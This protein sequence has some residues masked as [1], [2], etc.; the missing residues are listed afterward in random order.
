[1]LTGAT[2][3]LFAGPWVTKLG[4]TWIQQLPQLLYAVVSSDPGPR[5]ME[6]QDFEVNNAE[7]LML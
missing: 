6:V 1:M 3:F 2:H 5:S 7:L 4:N